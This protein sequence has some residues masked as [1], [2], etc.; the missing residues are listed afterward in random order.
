MNDIPKAFTVWSRKELV[1]Y[2][3]R[4]PMQLRAARAARAVR[5]GH[6]DF[7]G[8]VDFAKLETLGKIIYDADGIA[9][10]ALKPPESD[11]STVRALDCL[12]RHGSE[13]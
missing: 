5:E 4:N 6:P 8:P 11:P 1:A 3:S 13:S 2:L 12:R 9:T 10:F 7:I